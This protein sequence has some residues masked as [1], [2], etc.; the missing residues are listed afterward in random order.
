MRKLILAIFAMH[1]WKNGNKKETS[2]RYSLNGLWKFS[3]AKNYSSTI[4]GFEE[5]DYDCKACADI[6]VP[7]H[8]QEDAC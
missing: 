2:F 3:Y 8:I 6:K 4:K 1:P 7:A 5:E